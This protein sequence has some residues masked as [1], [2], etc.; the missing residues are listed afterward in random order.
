MSE[1]PLRGHPVFD[2]Y[3]VL[4]GQLQERIVGQQVAA[5]K[6]A[7]H[8][9]EFEHDQFQR[10]GVPRVLFLIGPTGVGKTEFCRALAELLGFPFLS[11]NA[12]ELAPTSFRG[13]QIGSLLASLAAEKATAAEGTL[14]AA[15]QGHAP[16]VLATRLLEQLS[17]QRT[18][19]SERTAIQAV[20]VIDE[21]DK[22]T[23]L[24]EAQRGAQERHNQA[25]QSMLLP[26]FEGGRIRSTGATSVGSDEIGEIDASSLLVVATGAFEGDRFKDVIE[27]RDSAAASFSKGHWSSINHGDLIAFGLMPELVGRVATIAV[28][29]QWRSPDIRKLIEK[30]LESGAWRILD[31]ELLIEEDALEII[32]DAANAMKLGARGAWVLLGAIKHHVAT[33]ARGVKVDRAGGTITL[34]RAYA[35]EHWGL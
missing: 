29:E 4:L 16:D 23:F 1:H 20:L 17:S 32:S 12:P 18:V 24:P 10:P 25:V 14:A 8:I 15:G 13:Q 34:S 21:M 2:R 6:L 3:Q 5:E 9:A 26:V 11:V 27:R 7:L 22:I 30:Y 31:H 35:E 33:T 28:L 19:A